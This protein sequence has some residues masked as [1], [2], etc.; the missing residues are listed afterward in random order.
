MFYLIPLSFIAYKYRYN[1][2]WYLMWTYSFLE[3]KYV[4]LTA[5]ADERPSNP[6]EQLDRTIASFHASPS[7]NET[8]GAYEISYKYMTRPYVIAYSVPTEGESSTVALEK[9]QEVVQYVY[10]VEKGELPPPKQ[11]RWIDATSSF[12]G[13]SASTESPMTYVKKYGGPF[14]DFYEFAD[15]HLPKTLYDRIFKDVV[16]TDYKLDEYRF[17]ETMRLVPVS[18]S[19]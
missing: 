15:Y 9:A 3:M 5:S 10:F 4:Q 6:Q 16:L 2:S 1:I 19:S 18:A 14:G 12:A 17:N 8:L 7:L 13:S 11:Y